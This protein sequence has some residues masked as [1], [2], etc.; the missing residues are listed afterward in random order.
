MSEIVRVRVSEIE[1]ETAFLNT[2]QVVQDGREAAAR[3][4]EFFQAFVPSSLLRSSATTIYE[5]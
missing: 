2:L 5:P 4:P 3:H 1:S